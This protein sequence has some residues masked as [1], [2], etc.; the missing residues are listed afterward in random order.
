MR[1]I[2]ALL[3]GYRVEQLKTAKREDKI[4]EVRQMFSALDESLNGVR[5]APSGGWEGPESKLGE[6]MVTADFTY[7]LLE[8]V[9]RQVIPGYERKGFA[10]EPL[11]KPDTLPN[12]LPVTRYQNRAGLDDLEYVAEKGEARP[13]SV[14]DATKRQYRVYQWKKQFDF[15]M[16]AIVN[17]DLGYFSDTAD[18]MGQAARR[19]LEKFVSRMYTNATTIARLVAL[20]ALYSTTGRLNSSRIS[21]ARMAFNQRLDARNEP[22]VA[23]LK[24]I[25]YHSGL[26]DTVRTIRQSQLVP[27]LATNAANVVAG[28]FIP[29]ED[30]YIVGTAPNLPWYAF[31]DATA[32]GITPFVLA[33]RTGMPAPLILRKKSDIESFTSFTGGGTPQSPILGDFAT[34]NIV[35]MVWDEWGTYIDGTDGNMFDTLGCYYSAGTAA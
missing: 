19:T 31:T 16:Q 29:I 8:F 25:V 18:K 34:N 33:R 15:S 11:V 2:V 32:S 14:R 28:D 22:V 10:F 3:E 4:A 1:K 21:A 23:S 30:P 9:Q 7:A 6:V 26:V 5:L 27:E 24:Y 20:G 17:D 12:Y 13:G 35:L